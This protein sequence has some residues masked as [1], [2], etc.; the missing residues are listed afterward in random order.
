MLRN[1]TNALCPLC[2]RGDSRL[3][4][5]VEKGSTDEDIIDVSTNVLLNASLEV[6]GKLTLADV[7]KVVSASATK[8]TLAQ[9][10]VSIQSFSQM[11]AWL[12]RPGLCK[13]ILV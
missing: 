4:I 3:H 1:D 12:P 13:D 9:L 8:A 2:L 6:S 11:E 10:L 7:P 5:L